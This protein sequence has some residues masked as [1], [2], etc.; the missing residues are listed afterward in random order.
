MLFLGRTADWIDDFADLRGQRIGIGPAGSGTD[1]VA[2]QI[3]GLPEFASLNVTLSNHTIEDQLGMASRGELDLAIVIID[4][5]APLVEEWVGHRGLQIASFAKAPA[6]ARRLPHLQTGHVGAGNYDAVRGVPRTDRTVMKVETLLIGN[7]CAGR[8]ATVDLLTLLSARAA[9]L[10]PTQQGHTQ[11]GGSGAGA[12][13]RR[14]LRERW[15]AARGRV[16]AVAGGR[17]APRQLGL[18][19]DGGEP[20]LQHDGGRA[21][22]PFQGASTPRQA[23]EAGRRSRAL[24]PALDHA[25]GTSSAPAPD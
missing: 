15:S 3:F 10:P 6:V 4:A 1:S 7:G 16:P 19:G 13:G 12:R 24:L 14:L 11:R 2:R 18:R 5:D 21:P 8:V 22:R 23:S 17:H 9:G 25:V 20:A